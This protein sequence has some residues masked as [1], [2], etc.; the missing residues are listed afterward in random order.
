VN[1]RRVFFVLFI[2][3][4]VLGGVSNDAWA[5]SNRV[6]ASARSGSDLNTCNNI[7]TPCQTFQGAVNQ[8]ATGGTVIVLDTGGYGPVTIGKALTID[9]PPGIVAFIHPP[10]GIAVSV[11]AGATDTVVLRGLSL[12]VG[13]GDGISVTSVG[14]LYVENCTIVGF[15][16]AGLRFAAAG[17]LFVKDSTFSNNGGEGILVAPATGTASSSIDRCRLEGNGGPYQTGA[18]VA[19]DGATVTVRDSVASGNFRGFQAGTNTF[20]TVQLNVESCV[21]TGNVVGL[22]TKAGTNTILRSSDTVV[23]NNTLYGIEAQQSG[24][25]HGSILS[26]SNNTVE[27]NAAAQTFSGTYAAR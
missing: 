23:T 8:V 21:S 22:F 7:T 5:Q 10:S 24:F 26:R 18:L 3:G 27:G 1:C 14:A 19:G 15:V 6:F 13:T 25:T 20:Q 11:A 2:A 12:N 16:S 9:A 4:I 17:Q